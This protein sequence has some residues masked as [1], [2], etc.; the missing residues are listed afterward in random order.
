MNLDDADTLINQA[1]FL[2]KEEKY[3]EAKRKYVEASKIIGFSADVTYSIALCYYMQ[4][5][6]V[7]ALKNIA[8][9]VEKGI[10]EHPGMLI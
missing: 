6:Y 3:E 2:F 5:Q 10:R 7:S 1:C 4:R 9:I 8:D